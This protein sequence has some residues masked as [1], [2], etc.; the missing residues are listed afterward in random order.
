MKQKILYAWHAEANENQAGK[1]KQAI[2]IK[3]EYIDTHTSVTFR[4][5]DNQHEDSATKAT[6]DE[7]QLQRYNTHHFDLY[8]M[9]S[10]E[11]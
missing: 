2:H 1:I 4:V 9:Q 5:S 7:Q 8:H 10:S 3:G 11:E 6:K